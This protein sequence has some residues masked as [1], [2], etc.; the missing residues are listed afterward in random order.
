MA[1]TATA[2]NYGF[3]DQPDFTITDCTFKSLWNSVIK[4]IKN[5]ARDDAA[6][7]GWRVKFEADGKLLDI[8]IVVRCIA[9]TG[10]TNIFANVN[11]KTHYITS[12]LAQC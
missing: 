2:Y 12:T 10:W 11:G 8:H 3:E 6:Y 1:Y 9:D 4:M 7:D 5:F